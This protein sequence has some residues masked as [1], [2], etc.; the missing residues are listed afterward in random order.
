[1][2]L[3]IRDSI[4]LAGAPEIRLKE[5]SAIL[6]VESYPE[7]LNNNFE[8]V[9]RRVWIRVP[10]EC[11]LNSALTPGKL[12]TVA[13]EVDQNLFDSCR[14]SIYVTVVKS[15]VKHERNILSPSRLVK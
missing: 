14:V 10:L 7:I 3:R 11:D 9:F 2:R 5:I 13:H 12:D 4:K 1:M 15:S 8:S 6:V